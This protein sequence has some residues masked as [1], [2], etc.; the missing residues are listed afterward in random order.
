MNDF[1]HDDIELK[2]RAWALHFSERRTNSKFKFAKRGNKKHVTTWVKQKDQTG[3]FERWVKKTQLNEKYKP[4][5]D[6][7][8][9][10][11][12]K[13]KLESHSL[14]HTQRNFSRRGPKYHPPKELDEKEHQDKFTQHS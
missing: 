8:E 1:V 7:L 2:R 5:D 14:L 12:N 4:E 11:S 13:A 9:Q 3:L 10:H 6:Q